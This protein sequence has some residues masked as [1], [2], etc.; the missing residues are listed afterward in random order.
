MPVFL[1]ALFAQI[2]LDFSVSGDY[3]CLLQ[4][5]LPPLDGHC[6]VYAAVA[7]CQLSR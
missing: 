1:D 6:A 5:D 7:F 2:H 3:D 4:R